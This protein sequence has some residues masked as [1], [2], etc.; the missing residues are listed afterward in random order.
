MS[1]KALHD[2]TPILHSHQLHNLR[3]LHS[4]APRWG[5]RCVTTTLEMVDDRARIHV[6]K[7][8]DVELSFSLTKSTSNVHACQPSGVCFVN[9]MYK[10]TC[11]AR[12]P[13]HPL[14]GR[15]VVLSNPLVRLVRAFGR[16]WIGCLC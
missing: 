9:G 1:C 2:G 8:T 10:A 11:V 5:Q 13:N 14:K 6:N 16:C 12:P 7:A 4:Q 15:A 3:I